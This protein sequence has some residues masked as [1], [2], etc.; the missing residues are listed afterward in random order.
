MHKFLKY[1]IFTAHAASKQGFCNYIFADHLFQ[2]F[3]F[4]T[5]NAAAAAWMQ[6]TFH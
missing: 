2:V 5:F 4:L 3:S 1:E 6:K